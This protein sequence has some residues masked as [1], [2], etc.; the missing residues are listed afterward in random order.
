MGRL[1]TLVIRGNSTDVSEK[2]VASISQGR[3]ESEAGSKQRALLTTWFIVLF[4]YPEDGSDM[5]FRNVG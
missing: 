4:F 3:N 2:Y 5:F 1:I